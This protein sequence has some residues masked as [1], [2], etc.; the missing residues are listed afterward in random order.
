MPSAKAT[1][2]GKVIAESDKTIKVEGNHYFP[3][4]SVE[5]D[6]MQGTDLS[7]LCPWKG[8][9][10]Y[11]TINSGKNEFKNAAWTYEDPIS[12]RA[13]PIKDYIAFY[14]NIVTIEDK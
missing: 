3:R 12:E 8:E 4:S 9:A 5:M 1:I 13:M 6:M 7:T 14:P 2:D 10:S 11:F